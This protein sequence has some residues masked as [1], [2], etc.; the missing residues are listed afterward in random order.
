MVWKVETLGLPSFNLGP[1]NAEI[2]KKNGPWKEELKAQIPLIGG[3]WTQKAPFFKKVPRNLP[4]D[5][6]WGFIIS[7]LLKPGRNYT[8]EK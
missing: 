6:K 8:N 2:S 5:L 7:K 1:Q 3:Y 4:K